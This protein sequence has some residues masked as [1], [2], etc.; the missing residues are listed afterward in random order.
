MSEVSITVP[1][2]YVER[3]KSEALETLEHAAGSLKEAAE[4]RREGR[5]DPNRLDRELPRLRA[6]ERLLERVR[7]AN[8]GP[9][10]VTGDR[11]VVGETLDGCAWEAAEKVRAAVERRDGTEDARALIAELDEWLT[12]R[13]FH[14]GPEGVA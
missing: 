8:G 12:M 1:A 6:A 10:Q 13:D 5:G 11:R 14:R 4:W 3:F 7:Q 2:E 9:L